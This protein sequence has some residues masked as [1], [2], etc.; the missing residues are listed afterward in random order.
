MKK[1]GGFTLIE[2]IVTMA[3]MSIIGGVA[4][5]TIITSMR[6][7]QKVEA[8]SLVH[9]DLS[10]AL[11]KFD[12]VIRSTTVILEA[13][14]TTLKIRGYPTAA[15]TVPSQIYFFITAGGALHYTIIPPT[16]TAPNYTYN[17]NNAKEYT[18]MAK[19]TNSN[20]APLFGY[21]NSSNQLLTYPVTLASI[22]AVQVSIQA[23][24]GANLLTTPIV[25]STII[26]MRNFKTNL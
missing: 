22:Q 11:D 9:R 5:G 6:N 24:D 25:A 17:Q 10:N 7:N 26:D 15:D 13:T 3:L 12:R 18:L 23:L 1:S 20:A 16:G 2:I 19:V 14:Q 4:V 8:Q 21:F